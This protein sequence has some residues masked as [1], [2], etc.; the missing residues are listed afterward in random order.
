MSRHKSNHPC[1]A[2][3]TRERAVSHLATLAAASRLNSKSVAIRLAVLVL[4][5]AAVLV[6][7]GC[8]TQG[9]PGDY[10]MRDTQSTADTG[11]ADID[12]ATNVPTF[13]DAPSF[14]LARVEDGG[15]SSSGPS[16]V[17]AISPDEEVWIIAR[18]SAAQGDQPGV[19]PTDDLY[20][21][22]GAMVTELPRE[23]QAQPIRVPLPL[24]H[25][26]V[27]AA[28]DG[29]I[30]TVDVTQQF[31]NPYDTKIEATYVFPLPQD[32]AVTDFA[33]IIGDR[34]I[35]GLIRD[36][37]EAQ[38]IYEQARTAGYRAAIMTQERPN[39]FTQ[40]V[41]NI[42][43]GKRI[44]VQLRFFNTL[45]Y[46][47]GW[48]S[49]RFPTVVGPRFNPPGAADPVRALPREGQSVAGNGTNI[50]YL[51]PG[52]RS[53][54]DIA[55][56][57]DLDPGVSI[58]QIQ[59]TSHRIE[60]QRPVA[61]STSASV[62]LRSDD[63]IP[64]KDFV[65][66]FKV[67]GER[68]ESAMLAHVEEATDQTA[69][70]Y[71]TLMLYP[72]DSLRQLQRQPMEMVFVIDCSGSMAGQPITQAKAAVIRALDLMQPSDTF[73]VIR[74]S[75]QASRFGDRPVPATPDRIADAKR[76]VNNLQADGG[77]MMDRGLRAALT[78]PH[79]DERF[80]V[81]TFLT[82][83]FI[84]DDRDMLRIVEENIGPSRIFS[85]GVGSSPNT[86]L[87][88]RMA[89]VGRGAAAYV[90]LD[91][92][93]AAI[94]QTYFDR[95]SHPAM[96]DLD[97]DWGDAAVSD[98]YPRQL[99]DLFVGRPVIVTGRYDPAGG[100]LATVRVT[101]QAGGGRPVEIVVNSEG[102]ATRPALAKVWARRKI[103][104]LADRR[105]T[106]TMQ[107]DD[108]A[109]AIRETALAYGLMSDYT[110]MLAVDASQRTAGDFGVSV[111]QAVP[112]PDG[113]RYDTTV[114]E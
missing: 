46:S 88:Q 72:P 36:R 102:D 29:Y 30:A 22:T 78:F 83:G 89:G 111:E 9:G 92:D 81:V 33:M 76:F 34:R 7:W 93:A 104:D 14:D 37:E 43:P 64:N 52:E 10:S 109:A 96:T 26:D 12:T 74:F 90:G 5:A 42:E 8:E 112:V 84:G 48:Y 16:Q 32:A 31:A 44:D 51:A 17:T 73:Q 60:V 113:V 45:A 85:F 41:A 28:V 61:T 114:P 71:F 35:R 67:A 6:G 79:D 99:P 53:G 18:P 105:D 15:Q 3:A 70:G 68:I 106:G 101:G 58:E 24:Q 47:D 95:I 94:M 98:V 50:R 19:Q 69:D 110:A 75:D 77:T 107:A 55:L 91:D 87:M 100:G 65:L 82:D 108:A 66:N 21:G 38:Q 2:A 39:I 54:H 80:R 97:I 25:T 56:T 49:F 40:R 13:N 103:A 1:R 57:V 20:P 23:G 63:T 62:T 27:R 86:Y 59:S 11:A 4:L